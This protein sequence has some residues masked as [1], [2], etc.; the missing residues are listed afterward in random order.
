MRAC[1]KT[2]SLRWTNIAAINAD[3]MNTDR[4]YK[5]FGSFCFHICIKF[6]VATSAAP[7]SLEMTNSSMFISYNKPM[8]EISIYNKFS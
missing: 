2:W 4:C 1:V 7:V 3:L 8:L 6:A 5:I